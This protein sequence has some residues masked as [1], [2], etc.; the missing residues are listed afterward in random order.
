M[1]KGNEGGRRGAQKYNMGEI[2]NL[3]NFFVGFAQNNKKQKIL[4]N[5]GKKEK[6]HFTTSERMCIMGA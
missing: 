4:E 6:K 5:F 2:Y 3:I 1:K